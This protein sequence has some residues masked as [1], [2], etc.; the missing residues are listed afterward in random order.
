[1]LYLSS[2]WIKSDN[3]C[4]GLRRVAS[5][6]ENI[7]LSGGLKYQT[8]LFEDIND[9]RNELGLNLLVHGYFPTARNEN[10]L[11]NLSDCNEATRDFIR[12]SMKYVYEFAIPYYSLHAGFKQSFEVVD[13]NF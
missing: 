8:R 4:D 6:S 13:N 2:S 11:L 5:I 7:E 9:I 1:M 12:E 3:Y 10:F